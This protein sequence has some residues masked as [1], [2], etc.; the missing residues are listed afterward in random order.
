MIQQLVIILAIGIVVMCSLLLILTCY[1]VIQ[2]LINKRARLL[3]NN[4]ITKH[5]DDW[6]DYLINE[7]DNEDLI[8]PAY[9][10]DFA[11]IEEILG[12]YKKNVTSNRL[13]LR[14]SMFANDYMSHYYCK[15]LHHSRWSIRLNAIY[16]VLDFQ[17]D[18]LTST[19]IEMMDSGRKYTDQEYFHMLKI[20]V[21]F[22]PEKAK[23]IFMRPPIKLG[24]FEYRQLL[25][26]LHAETKD[27]L[28][29]LFDNLP[30]PCQYALIKVIAEKNDRNKITFLEELIADKDKEMRIRALKAIS[31]LGTISDVNRY[32]PIMDSK[33]WEERL[34]LAKILNYIPVEQSSQPL[35][36]LMQDREWWVR[37]QAAK[38]LVNSARGKLILKEFIKETDDLYAK[39]MANNVIQESL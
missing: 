37:Y 30:E 8:K 4:Y 20:V 5:A 7:I 19:V 13:S 32:L 31:V 3:I 15:R 38:S 33:H 29:L 12:K 35:K 1:V 25:L 6:Y 28:L 21:N 16:R 34:M 27:K 24:E 36:R 18:S 11:A 23:E 26:L 17:I 14:I 22:Q 9:A 39:E 2:R 10:Q